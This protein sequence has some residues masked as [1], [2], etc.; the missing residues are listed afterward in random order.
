MLPRTRGAAIERADRISAAFQ[1]A[2]APTTPTGRLMPI[3]NAPVSE[4]ITSPSGAYASAAACR[5]RPGTK[6]IWNMPKPNVH[7]VSRASIDTTSSWRDSS[8]SAAFRKMPCR[9]AGG[10]RDHSGKAS[11]AASTARFASAPLALATSETT[12]PLQ[13]SRFSNVRPPSASTNAPPMKS[14][15]S[16]PVSVWVLIPGLL[17]RPALDPTVVR[18]SLPTDAVFHSSRH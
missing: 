14:L 13:G 11:A 6:C 15:V 10:V 18:R 9:T 2:I 17:S 7:P 3:A 16:M 12:S 1:G 5:K 4:G 8:T